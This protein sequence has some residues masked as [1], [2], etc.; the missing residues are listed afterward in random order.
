MKK[1]FLIACLILTTIMVVAQD[2]L[3]VEP[4]PPATPA[5]PSPT[6][7]DRKEDR[8]LMENGELPPT[9]KNI[10][11]S[12]EKFKGWEEGTIYLDRTSGQFLLHIIRENKTET[13]RFDKEGTPITTDKHMDESSST[14]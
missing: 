5:R 13:F 10:L 12:D 8:L 2:S 7:A 6:E 14:Q 4:M 11:D 9:L 1:F 3:R